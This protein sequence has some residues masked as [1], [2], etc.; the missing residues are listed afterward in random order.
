MNA[1]E[2]LL[3][4]FTSITRKSSIWSK[5]TGWKDPAVA[6]TARIFV[7]GDTCWL[8]G[9][10]EHKSWAGWIWGIAGILQDACCFKA[11]LYLPTASIA[12]LTPSF[13]SLLTNDR[14]IL[15]FNGKTS[16]EP[17][18]GAQ[19]A[20]FGRVTAKAIVVFLMVMTKLQGHKTSFQAQRNCHTS[21]FFIQLL[22]ALV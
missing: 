9:P 18:V 20:H 19:R 16:Q 1:G 7:T 8:S 5:I 21:F 6:S 10:P 22:E 17:A 12:S 3:S 11:L 2:Q 4:G 13:S 14:S 15:V